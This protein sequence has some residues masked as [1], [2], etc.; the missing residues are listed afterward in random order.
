M[1]L[2][3]TGVSLIDKILLKKQCFKMNAFCYKL[4]VV[5]V[6]YSVILWQ[7]LIIICNSNAMNY[8][9][10]VS[11]KL[12]TAWILLLVL[13]VFS[14]SCRQNS[15]LELALKFAS[16]NRIE[17]EKVLKHYQDSTLKYKAACFLIENMPY[18]FSY[19]GGDLDSVRMAKTL[20]MNGYI[21]TKIKK[22]WQ[23]FDYTKL[24][25]VHDIHVITAEYLINNIDLSFDAWQKYPW[26][27]YLPFD[28]FCE[29]ILPYRISDEPLE[30][31]RQ[32]YY[33]RFSPLLDSLYQGT[34]VVEAVDTLARYLRSEQFRFNT[35]LNLPHLGPE[36]LL[37]YRLGSCRESTDYAV[38]ILRALGIPAAFDT[39]LFS[40]ER[41]HKHMWN[42][43]RDTTGLFHYFG[44]VEG[45]PIG[46]GNNDGRK[47]GKV[48]RMCY[49]WQP[50][51]RPGITFDT[52]LPFGL[53]DPFIKDVTAGYFSS[54]TI[55]VEIDAVIPQQDVY[56]GVFTSQ[57]WTPIDVGESRNGK[58]L[59]CSIEPDVIY[60]S[61]YLDEDRLYPI[62]FP[63]SVQDTGMHYFQPD[64]TTLIKAT[65]MRKF[66]LAEHVIWHLLQSSKTRIYGSNTK[67]FKHKTLLYRIPSRPEI[68][69]NVFDINAS[70]LQ[71]IRVEADTG[72]FVQLAEIS[73]YASF[74]ENKKLN[75]KAIESTLPN[76]EIED[77]DMH[78]A[79]DDDNL[80][81][82]FS[83]DRGGYIDFDLGSSQKLDKIVYVPQNDENFITI[84]DTYELFYNDGYYG[85]TSLGKRIADDTE[86]IYDNIPRNALLWLRNLS[87]GREEQ[88]FWIENGEQVFLGK[89]DVEKYTEED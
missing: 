80:T 12:N 50:G 31:W 44:F 66:P 18:Y 61:L 16:E 62:G 5:S 70:P 41:Q 87:R 34:D 68:N 56:L 10:S 88:V 27:K 35:D 24:E 19:T 49:G 30:N 75:V 43:L 86:L 33:E 65:L 46:R 63:F 28:E 51:K 15:R 74:F 38:Y 48:Y 69:Y 85:W 79:V 81:Y 54:D 52:R 8:I 73:F 40:P 14:P 39:Y 29:L 55:E 32:I 22:E 36:F 11:L 1:L 83:K 59:F 13:S 58:L 7:I 47:K 37:K 3:G 9:P 67:D 2:R 4:Y 82:Y 25:R 71:Y 20:A 21:D 53:R 6:I 64:T 77:Y 26:G 42:V 57:G 72:R 17:L 78:K 76:L 60:Q 45:E 84:G 23:N 89:C